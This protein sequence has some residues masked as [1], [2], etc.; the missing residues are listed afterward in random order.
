MWWIGAPLIATVVLFFA[1][2]FLLQVS[3]ALTGEPAPSFGRALKTA[4]LAWLL[5]W[6]AA[7]SFYF[8]VGL[9]VSAAVGK[10]I[11]G[12]LLLGVTTLVYRRQL[13]SS[14]LQSFIVAVIQHVLGGLLTFATW[15]VVSYV[16]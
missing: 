5:A 14:V 7:S 15:G 1:Q 6:I 2:G 11:Y 13:G 16:F 8:T 12:L 9:F 4:L 10:L 3:V